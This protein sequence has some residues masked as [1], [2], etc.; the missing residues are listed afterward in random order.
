MEDL[1]NL[2]FELDNSNKIKMNCSKDENF[3]DLF[4][5]I[6]SKENINDYIF[7]NESD[8]IDI[9]E[10]LKI[11]TIN[12]EKKEIKILGFSKNNNKEDY[13][14][15]KT[16]YKNIICPKCQRNTMINFNDYK[17][18]LSQCSEGHCIQN[19]LLNKFYSTQKCDI[20]ILKEKNNK[21][22][23][24]ESN[25]APTPL[26]SS[27]LLSEDINDKNDDISSIKCNKHNAKFSSYCLNCNRNLCSECEMNHNI[28]RNK[29]YHKIIHFYEILSNNDEYI[30]NLKKEMEKF[31]IK[32]DS[33]KIELF[34]IENIINSVMNNYEIY[35][36]IYNDMVNNYNI[37]TRNYHIL[38]N[39]TNIKLD[40]VFEDLNKINEEG[41]L[42]K[43]FENIYE[44]YNKMNCQNEIII[45][46]LPEN[47]KKL[48][49]FG[50]KFVV[51]N[52]NK[53]KII[54]NNQILE[55]ND[56][57]I[58][59][60]DL[61][62][63]INSKNGI[64][65]IKLKINKNQ[66]LIDMSHMF[67]DCSSLLFLPN[68]SE[69][70]TFHV[71][72]MSYLFYGCT[73]LENLSD[74]SKWNTSNVTNMNYMFFNCYSLLSLPN[75]STWNISNCTDLSHMFSNCSSLKSLPDISKWKTNNV[76]NISYL[77]YYCQ[78]LKDL[79]DISKWNTNKINNI[80][81]LFSCCI[82]L[83]KIPDISIWDTS[84]VYDVSYLFYGCKS[85][86]YLPDI[87]KWNTSK[88]TNMGFMFDGLNPKINIPKLTANEFYII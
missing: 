70:N 82:S 38:K 59:N 22:K 10:K 5:R 74:I 26:S 61:R 25:S 84:Q 37:E 11:N 29:D 21:L 27:P 69:L 75:I 55:L 19:L 3:S 52:R 12:N 71:K 41:H 39:I 67:K 47:S 73:L 14:L 17:I 35:Y 40:E 13:N 48:R 33:L 44:I 63:Y 81:Y 42:F 78:S 54:L 51:N 50:T 16:H 80:S 28:N 43:K 66:N 56:I 77:F 4:K 1:L 64:L 83:T 76:T 88:I 7:F 2:T 87:T 72:D 18:T 53:F 58:I 62:K 30:K 15:N 86:T 68:I 36:K 31:K 8:I 20:N 85:L 24:I 6:Y 45:Q 79:P 23:K 9:D 60:N 65:E 57:I 32:L 46:Y 49:L 34:Q